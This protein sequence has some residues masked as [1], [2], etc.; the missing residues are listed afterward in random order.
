MAFIFTV[1]LKPLKDLKRKTLFIIHTVTAVAALLNV[2][3]SMS[4]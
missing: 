4:L 3:E 1:L 2:Y